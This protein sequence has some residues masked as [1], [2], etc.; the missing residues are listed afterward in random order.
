MRNHHRIMQA[1]R[2]TWSRVFDLPPN[3]GPAAALAVLLY[4]GAETGAEST[5]H[6]YSMSPYRQ[7]RKQVSGRKSHTLAFEIRFLGA[8]GIQQ[9]LVAEGS[10]S[11]TYQ[12]V[13]DTPYWI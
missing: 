6:S 2:G 3:T 4:V 7:T 8:F 1:S 9:T 12:R 5:V 13:S 10:R 11:R